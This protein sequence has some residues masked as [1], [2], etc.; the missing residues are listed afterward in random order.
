[1]ELS[2]EDELR[3]QVLLANAEAVRI[4]EQRMVVYG[5]SPEREFEVRLT[6]AGSVDRY[7]QKVRAYLSTAVLGSP[8]HYPVHL[9]RWAGHGQ[10][11]NAP[12]EKLLLLGNPEAVFAVACSPRLTAALARRVWWVAPGPDMARQLLRHPA[13]SLDAVGKLLAQW[14]VD[15]LP[16][17][18][19]LSDM[20]DSARLLLQ[21]NLIDEATRIRLWEMGRRNKAYR[22]GFLLEC[23]DNLPRRVEARTDVLGPTDWF[24][25]PEYAE[26]KVAQTLAKASRA[27]GQS[28]IAASL[29]VLGGLNSQEEA[30]SALKAIGAYYSDLRAY[31]EHGQTL[32]GTLQWIERTVAEQPGT[33]AFYL[34]PQI[35]A[36]LRAL[37]LL[38]HTS[39]AWV[40]PIFAQSDAGGSVMRKQIEPVVMNIV[41]ALKLLKQ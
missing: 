40:T 38:A 21:P 23:P 5:L 7:L 22:I 31:G 34:E 6:P 11:D 17:E 8:K 25:H 24:A 26:S 29:D 18:T 2:S 35:Q 39:D 19:E 16:F 36:Q 27:N 41:N 12:L 20:L 4:D 33:N 32:E 14:L 1:M 15:Y 10:I 13:V 3:L 30:S 28:F 9:R 37:Y